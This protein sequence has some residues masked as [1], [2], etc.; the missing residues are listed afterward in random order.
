VTSSLYDLRPRGGGAVG[1]GAVAGGAVA[2]GAVIEV[3]GP[4]GFDER[5]RARL[6]RRGRF[7]GRAAALA[8]LDAWFARAVAA[9]RRLCVLIT[10]AAGTG[11]SRLVA[12]LVAR[13]AAAGTAM[14]VTM[15]AASPAS[16]L[17]PFATVIDLYQ[18]ALGLAPA[19]GR[20][21]RAEVVRRLH[22][23]MT[24]AGVPEDRVRVVVTDLD[25]AMELR[26]GLG[27]AA[28]E[29]ADLR[30]RLSAG[31]AAFRTAMASRARPALTIIE[32]IHL[33]DT[34]SVEVLRHTLGMPALGP[35]LLVLTT[36]PEGPPPP[37]AD[38]VITL[39]DLVGQ[40]L[41]T[42]IADRLG[43]QATPMAIAA[44][45]ARGGGNPLFIEELAQAVRDA[46]PA[47]E[48]VPASARDVVSARIDRLTG[49]AKAA[50]RFA[51]AIGGTVRVRLLEEL[52]G[53]DSLERELDEL[54]AAGCL[55]RPDGAGEGDVEFA[56]GLVREVVY[57]SLSPRAQ[58]ETHAR[59][60]RL[61]ASRFFAGREEPPSTIAEH[62]E[63]GGER[64]GA[65]AFWLR[66]GRLALSASDT[67]AAVA[68]FTRTLGLEHELG[69]A[70]PTPTSRARRREALAGREE[71][72]RL[73]GDLA[74]DAGDLDA[75]EALSLGEPARLADVAIRRAQRMLRL[76]DYA[77]ANAATLAAE[78]FAIAVHDDRLRGEALRVRGEILERLGRFD[79][80]LAVVGAAGEL[81]HRQHA[82]SDEMAAMVGRGRIHLLRAHYE[83]ARDAYRP[84]LAMIAKTGDP[85]LERIVMNHVAVIEMCLG[86]F[87]TAM[88]SAQRSLEL[89]RR[90]GDRGREGDALSVA[91]II[92]L[93]VGLLEPA[94][95]MFGQALDT[96]AR[97]NSRWSHTDCL[98]YAGT[99][100]LRRGHAD[101]H[102]ML[103]D[104]LAEATRLGARYL[105]ANAL[106]TRAGA[107]LQA[108]ALAD[109][110]ADAARGAAVAREATLVGY[111]S[112]GLARHA[113]AL[114][115][116]GP[117]IG[118]TIA[119]VHRALD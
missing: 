105:E 108:G 22:H 89:C 102:R 86:N 35:E 73:Q 56:R 66:A 78:G 96:L 20:T 67:G 63:R 50:L 71:A 113:L 94:A 3:V 34:A 111:E 77:G 112:Q 117:R 54:V 16:R 59:V 97:T 46:G 51:S 36:R 83:A 110:I 75:L 101:G 9:D 80:A 12:E 17:A 40:E 29:V 24:R 25:R 82:V 7:V 60:G 72:H 115:R 69:E 26:D 74:S 45:L 91:G 109:A 42:L 68:C 58:R 118:E 39:G 119:L 48:D 93:E 15:A 18:A 87:A 47:G 114:A 92:L 79:D 28:R 116:L 2:G 19:R 84:V 85:W 88:H 100:E 55:V 8:D 38:L 27:V 76:G 57:E 6:E 70:P 44:V 98:I 21:A 13:H 41:R 90:Y 23:L 14:Q 106:V 53:E 81:F 32:D 1:S 5:D 11:K 31:I 65:A 52:L 37:A 33:A 43:D 10:G 95:A 4:R 61:L 30:P 104:A 103:D 62:L 49:K 99:C 64:A 107:H